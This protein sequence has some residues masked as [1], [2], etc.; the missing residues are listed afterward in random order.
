MLFERWDGKT[1]FAVPNT[2]SSTSN[3]FLLSV[4]CASSSECWAAGYQNVNNGPLHPLLAGWDGVSWAAIPAPTGNL[5]AANVLYDTAC[6]SGSRCWVAG[7]DSPTAF[8]SQTFIEQYMPTG[9]P[10]YLVSVSASPLEGGAVDGGARYPSGGEAIVSAA[11][12]NEYNFA[13]WVE[14]GSI[15][16]TLL[17][18]DFI[19]SADRM[20]VANFIPQPTVTLSVAPKKVRKNGTATFTITAT[21]VNPSQLLT[22]NYAMSGT[23]VLGSDYQISGVP[24]QIDIP[25]GQSSGSLV[26]TVTTSKTR[27]SE[28]ATMT[29]TSGGGY[30]LPVGK[31]KKTTPPPKVSVKISNR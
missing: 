18:Y 31:R 8:I 23:A 3:Q 25:P 30:K 13:N 19:A 5:G 1:W 29:L 22:I 20:L 26:L 2:S 16:S 12:N 11:P 15:V 14:N 27:G 4:A 10:N 9:L 6:S 17:S 21:T 28:K 7:Y 24:G